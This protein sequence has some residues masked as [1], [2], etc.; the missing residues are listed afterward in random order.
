MAATEQAKAALRHRDIVLSLGGEKW[1]WPWP[2]GQHTSLEQGHLRGVGWWSR[3]YNRKRKWE[4]AHKLWRRQNKA[5]G[6][7][8]KE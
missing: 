2:W 8:G 3:R 6:W 7:H 5:S 1:P 4:G